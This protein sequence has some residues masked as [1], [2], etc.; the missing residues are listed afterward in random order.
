MDTSAVVDKLNEILEW[1][2]AGV[3]RYTHYSMMVYG[4]ARI[5]IISYY[6]GK[7]EESL[8]HAH[9]AGEWITHLGGH[10]TLKI[11]PLLETK[12]HQIDEILRESYQHEKDHQ[13]KY[14]ELL[15]LVRDRHV[16][17]EE[18]ARKAITD[19]ELH[20]G[21]IDKMLRRPG[22]LEAARE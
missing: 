12:K 2:L 22:Q 19:E 17:L 7:A 6:K 4:H 9:A 20:I 1:E 11:G 5:P 21:E 14:Y 18:F 15:A 8:L 3:V 10:P 13:Q 16:P